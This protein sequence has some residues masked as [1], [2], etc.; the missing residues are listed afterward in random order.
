MAIPP[1]PV[2]TELV[3]SVN[4][5][6]LYSARGLDQS[7]E[8]IGASHVMRRTING[9]LVDLS[10]DKFRKYTSKISCSDVESPALDG[11][12][13]GQV[14]DV[15]CVS[16]LVYPTSGGTPTRTVVAGSART[17]GGYT[18]YRPRLTMMVTGVQQSRAEYA[19]TVS[20]ELDLEEV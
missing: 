9:I 14:L 8:P 13:P 10:V 20:W 1:L 5:V 19:R 4:G 16:E 6:S 3:L 12:F 7:L 11:I 15:D 18:V 17:V 2:A